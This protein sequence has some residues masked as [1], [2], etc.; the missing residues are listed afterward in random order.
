MVMDFGLTKSTIR[1]F[2]KS[3]DK[4]YTLWDKESTEFKDFIYK[5]YPRVVTTPISPS[6]ESYAILIYAYVR[7]ILQNTVFTN[8][9]CD[10]HLDSVKVH[11]TR[12]GY[13]VATAE[14]LINYPLDIS[15]LI[16]SDSIKQN[17]KNT[18]MHENLINHDKWI[19][20]KTEQQIVY[21]V[22]NNANW[23]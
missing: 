20:E 3:F 7:Q 8:N 1:D 12:T 2:V 15:K 23:D 13:A 4:S 17:W 14:D 6:A 18:N 19:N 11:E 10:I 22:N 16:F 9:E 21:E 5:N